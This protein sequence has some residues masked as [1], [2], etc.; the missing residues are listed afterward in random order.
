MPVFLGVVYAVLGEELA[1]RPDSRH[2][3]KWGYIWLVASHQ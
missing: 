2:C 1:E 3:S